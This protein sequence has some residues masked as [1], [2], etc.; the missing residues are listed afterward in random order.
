MGQRSVVPDS[1]SERLDQAPGER[2]GSRDRDLLTENRSD[3]QLKSIPT[4]GHAQPGHRFDPRHQ[5]WIR[6]K[7]RGDITRVSRKIEDAAHPLDNL[8][9]PTGVGK[10]NINAE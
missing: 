6:R 2:T 5:E 7:M 1:R 4:T 10:R 9:K 8:K 3:G